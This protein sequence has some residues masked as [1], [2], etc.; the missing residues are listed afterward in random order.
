MKVSTENITEVSVSS[1]EPLSVAEAK[2]HLRVDIS[3]DDS[4]IGDLISSAR[5]W[6]EEFCQQSFVQHSY[7]ADLPGFWDAMHLPLGPVQSITH[8][9]YYDTASPNALQTLSTNVY[10][11]NN[12]VVSRNDGQSWES[13]AH[14]SDAVQITYS[15]GWKD[16]SSPQGVGASVPR[17]VVQAMRLLIGDAYENREWQVL[18]PGQLHESR[19]MFNLL[20]AYRVYR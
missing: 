18:Y 5:A 2:S 1:T 12:N 15:T 4:Y 10:A 11:L 3:T 19:A 14:R 13:V 9:K 16:S 7:R 17:P 6:C 8:I 20:N